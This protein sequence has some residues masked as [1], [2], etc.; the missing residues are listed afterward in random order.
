MS[1]IRRI[2]RGKV[3]YLAEVENKRVDGKVIQKHIR[4]I[5]KEENGETVISMSSSDLEI[6]KVK[7]Y[8]PLLVLDK[9]L[10]K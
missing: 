10:G 6:E 8:G 4:Y 5:G 7:V 2:K 9:I 1:F 3:T